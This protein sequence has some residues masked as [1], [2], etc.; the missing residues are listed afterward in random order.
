MRKICMILKY[1]RST[2]VE[3]I[4]VFQKWRGGRVVRCLF[5]PPFCYQGMWCSGMTLLSIWLI[6]LVFHKHRWVLSLYLIP[7]HSQGSALFMSLQ[8]VWLSA[9]C[10]IMSLVTTVAIGLWKPYAKSE[11]GTNVWCMMFIDLLWCC[12]RDRN[13]WNIFLVPE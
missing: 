3:K 10:L 11:S 9:Y 12:L 8:Y 1:W 4:W 13:T 2:G 6:V 7:R 5:V